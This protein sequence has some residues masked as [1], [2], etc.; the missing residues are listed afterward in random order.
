MRLE[1]RLQ[2]LA[3]PDLGASGASVTRDSNGSSRCRDGERGPLAGGEEGLQHRAIEG[4]GR[5]ESREGLPRTR[6]V[7]RGLQV[8]ECTARAPGTRTLLS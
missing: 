4:A 5:S 3:K 2:P 1:L 8:P 6:G 7:W